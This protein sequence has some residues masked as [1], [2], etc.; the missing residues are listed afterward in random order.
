[1]RPTDAGPRSHS[2]AGAKVGMLP[3]EP[4]V[5]LMH[6]NDVLSVDRISGPV[7]REAVKILGADMDEQ[8][9]WQ[10][11]VVGADLDDT[12][13]VTTQLK[14]VCG[15]ARANVPQVE[16]LLAMERRPGISIRHRHLNATLASTPTSTLP[17]Q[18][19]LSENDSL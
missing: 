15:N 14:T 12:E 2:M 3:H 19:L 18:D 4:I 9:L 13:T 11:K 16:S 10:S 6:A 7:D 5:L 1:M 17:D 8:V